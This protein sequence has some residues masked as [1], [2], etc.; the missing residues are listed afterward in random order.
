M[1]TRSRNRIASAA[2]LMLGSVTAPAAWAQDGS[3][4]GW[5]SNQYGQLNVPPPNT[6]FVA[7]AAG[8]DHGL[9]LKADDSI[10]AWGNN[11]VGQLNVPAPN[12][13]FVAV[14]GGHGHSL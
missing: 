4:M 8:G 10:V 11:Q 13:G 5:G 2:A 1:N 9:G 12:E 7:L 6:G 14:A 3:I